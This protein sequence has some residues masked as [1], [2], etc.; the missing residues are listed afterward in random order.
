[1]VVRAALFPTRMPHA[2][3]VGLVWTLPHDSKNGGPQGGEAA[4]DDAEGGLD[5][6]VDQGRDG[7]VSDI[8]KVPIGDRDDPEEGDDA[9]SAGARQFP[10]AKCKCQEFRVF[11]GFHK[12]FGKSSTYRAPRLNMEATPSFFASFILRPNSFDMGNATMM[13][14]M[15]KLILPVTV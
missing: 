2:T 10:V 1:M 8:G 14:S 11:V 12:F 6:R 7:R 4:V 9:N 3:T 5:E 13:T 15:P